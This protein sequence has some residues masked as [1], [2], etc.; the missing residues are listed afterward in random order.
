MAESTRDPA[1]VWCDQGQILRAPSS[2]LQYIIMDLFKN[3]KKNQ[4]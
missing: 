4:H 1:G 2:L 3:T